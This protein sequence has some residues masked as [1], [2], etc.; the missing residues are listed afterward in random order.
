[1]LSE[2]SQVAGPVAVTVALAV[3][4]VMLSIATIVVVRARPEDLPE[5]VRG[6]ATWFRGSKK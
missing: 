6:L 5:I 3:L 4:I 2:F 1:M